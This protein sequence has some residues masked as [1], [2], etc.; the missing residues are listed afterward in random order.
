[1]QK[2][3]M[4]KKGIS[5]LIATVLLIG[6]TIGVFLIVFALIRGI[7]LGTI[8]KSTDCGAQEETSLDIGAE[9]TCGSENGEDYADITVTNNGNIKVEGFM[10]VFYNGE[11]G[12]SFPPTLNPT[13]PAEQSINKIKADSCPDR[14]E[15]YPGIVKETS[16]G[17]AKF[18]VCKDKKIEVLKS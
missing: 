6:A 17:K 9:F 1:M 10:F 5:P 11:E 12:K 15:I 18:L 2:R 8:E 13:K 4:A 7:T 16:Q 3:L 14:I